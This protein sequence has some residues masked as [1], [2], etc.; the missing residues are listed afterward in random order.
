M[1]ESEIAEQNEDMMDEFGL[2]YTQWDSHI[3][4]EP[5]SRD[6]MMNRVDEFITNLEDKK[7]KNQLEEF[8]DDEELFDQFPAILE[9]TGYTLDW[10]IF[11][12]NE[13]EAYVK[14]QISETL[15]RHTD[16]N[17]EIYEV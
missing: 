4:F 9:R 5:F 15:R 10:N 1:S 13:I 7:L 14:G 3:R 6:D 16:S 12:R 2:N 17:N 11:L 8:T